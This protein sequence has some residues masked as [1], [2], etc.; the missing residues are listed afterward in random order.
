MNFSMPNSAVNHEVNTSPE[1][2]HGA[3]AK[4]PADVFEASRIVAFEGHDER[5]RAYNMI[6]AQVVREL[7]GGKNRLIGITSPTP[8]AGKSL[9][10][11]NLA[12]AISR[13]ANRAVLLCD[14]DLRRG[15]VGEALALDTDADVA[16]YLR[17]EQTEWQSSVLRIAGTDMYVLPCT[18]RGRG[19]AELLSSQNF[20]NLIAGIRTL[21]SDVLV[22]CDLPPVFASDDTLLAAEHLDSYLL[23]VEYARNT[24][25]QVREAMRLLDQLPLLGTVLNRYRGGFFDAY[26]YG[27][28][29]PYGLREYGA[30][31]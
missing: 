13:I 2:P 20:E 27:Y 8:G 14:F 7:A 12:A 24:A 11:L 30:N 6:R 29:D 17:G 28:G 10:S 15:S 9:L 1:V 23:V 4:I 5:S 16:G 21:P 3:V 18:P 19:S 25:G 22:L 31:A 26:G